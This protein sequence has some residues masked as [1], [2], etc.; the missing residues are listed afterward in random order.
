MQSKGR[1]ISNSYTRRLVILASEDIGNANPN[2]LV[3]ANSCFESVNLI[4]LPEA[5]IILSQTVI[6]LATSANSNSAYLAIDKALA[7][8]KKLGA[9]PIPLH[10][11]NAPSELMKNLDYGK[12][13]KY[14]HDFPGNFVNQEFMPEEL[15]GQSFF[16][17][18]N[19]PREEEMRKKIQNWWAGKYT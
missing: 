1:Y 7:H 8:I 9:K 6:Y 3:L 2:A 14:A 11:R 18:A 4:G 13:Y 10:L 15:K 17:P 16:E 12:D 19:N 5:R